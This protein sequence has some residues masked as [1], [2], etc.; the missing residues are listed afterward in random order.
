MFAPIFAIVEMPGLR[1]TK[2]YYYNSLLAEFFIGRVLVKVRDG[3]FL[4]LVNLNPGK[5]E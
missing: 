3:R 2:L 5:Q 1:F 4:T